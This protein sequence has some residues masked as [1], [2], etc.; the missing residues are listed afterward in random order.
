MADDCDFQR[1]VIRIL[2]KNS[3][4]LELVTMAKDG[5]DLIEQLSV[6]QETPEVCILDL[7]MPEVDGVSAARQLANNF[8][9]II[10]F[11]YTS[12]D[13]IREI[14]RFKESGVLSVFPKENLQ[15][16]LKTIEKLRDCPHKQSEC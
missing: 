16:M 15:V 6:L 11:G 14:D 8:P 3:L 2:V 10:L 13:N 4:T 12:T 5:M 9:S 7:H 1:N